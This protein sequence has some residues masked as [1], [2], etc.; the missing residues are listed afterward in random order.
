[1]TASSHLLH[2]EAGRK[3]LRRSGLRGSTKKSGSVFSDFGSNRLQPEAR[4]VWGA[5]ASG[6]SVLV[7]S[8]A[9]LSELNSEKRIKQ[10]KLKEFHWKK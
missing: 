10:D 2:L 3:S 7:A 9:L 5:T 8:A 1:M 4:T 6:G